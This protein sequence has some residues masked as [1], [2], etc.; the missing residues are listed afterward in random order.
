MLIAP[1][2]FACAD[3]TYAS[4]LHCLCTTKLL[5]VNAYLQCKRINKKNLIFCVNLYESCISKLLQRN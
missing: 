4:N 3:G 5:N 2:L 1:R